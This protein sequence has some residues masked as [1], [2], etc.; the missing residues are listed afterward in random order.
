[1]N[2]DLVTVV[3]SVSTCVTALAALPVWRTRR[4]PARGR[5]G[6]RPAARDAR[7]AERGTPDATS[8]V[9]SVSADR[10]AVVVQIERH[11]AQPERKPGLG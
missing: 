1:M 7:G 6:D 8:F 5:A 10:P 2:Q 3:T 11:P 9:V 4:G